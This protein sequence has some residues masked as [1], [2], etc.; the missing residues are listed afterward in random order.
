MSYIF[1]ALQR[2]EAERS[3]GSPP[4]NVDSVVDLLQGVANRDRARQAKSSEW[5][6]MAESLPHGCGRESAASREPEV[7]STPLISR[8][9]GRRRNRILPAR[10]FADAKVLSPGLGI[11]GWYA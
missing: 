1:E 11:P 9:A 3:G 5:A 8:L 6:R 7:A 10:T 2:A 4:K